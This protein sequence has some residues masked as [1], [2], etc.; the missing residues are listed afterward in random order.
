MARRRF[1][2]WDEFQ[3]NLD[4]LDEPERSE[5]MKEMQTRIASTYYWA[6]ALRK[7]DARANKLEEKNRRADA[8]IKELEEEFKR[9]G[10]EL[11]A[12]DDEEEETDR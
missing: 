5:L 2:F 8:R 10:L 7:L 12:D 9:L 11:P 1:D 6:E 4:S 3:K